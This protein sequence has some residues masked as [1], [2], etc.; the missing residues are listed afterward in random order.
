MSGDRNRRRD[1]VRGRHV[2]GTRGRGR[3][4]GCVEP[5][6]DAFVAAINAAADW[7]KVTAIYGYVYS[8]AN[9][10]RAQA[11]AGPLW[12]RIAEIGTNRP[13]FANR[14]GVKLYDFDQLT[15]RRTGYSWFGTAPQ[16]R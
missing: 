5:I 16:R 14:D 4:L 12:A 6:Q 9:G 13:M 15:D 3:P 1:G 10:F 8:D 11:G 7:F 2:A